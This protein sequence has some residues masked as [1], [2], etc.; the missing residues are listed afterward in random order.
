MLFLLVA[1]LIRFYSVGEHA[2]VFVIPA[3]IHRA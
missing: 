3:E 1:Q 2:G